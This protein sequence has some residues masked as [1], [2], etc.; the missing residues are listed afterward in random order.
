MFA[1]EPTDSGAFVELNRTFERLMDIVAKQ[2][3]KLKNQQFELRKQQG[4]IIRL[5]EEAVKCQSNEPKDIPVLWSKSE[6]KCFIY[7]FSLYKS[8]RRI[9][10]H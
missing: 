2:E 5:S 3:R 8:Q 7:S 9:Q 1:L 6:Y 10:T 4:Q